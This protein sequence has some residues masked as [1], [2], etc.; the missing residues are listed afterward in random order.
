[1]HAT[2]V[3]LPPQQ[4]AA[5]LGGATYVNVHTSTLPGGALRGQLLPAAT[6][7]D[8]ASRTTGLGAISG[9]ERVPGGAAA[10]SLVGSN[11]AD[12]LR[13][14]GGA[15]TIVPARG[16]DVAGG[17]LGSDLIAWSNGDGSDTFDGEGDADRVQVNGAR[18]GMGEVFTVGAPG[19][20]VAFARTAPSPFTLDIGTTEKLAVAANDDADALTSTDL[21][22]AADLDELAFHGGNGDDTATI[23]PSPSVDGVARGGPGADTLRFDPGCL[24]VTTAPG[25]LT[26]A[27]LRPV[28]HASIETVDVASAVSFSAASGS[29]TEASGQAVIG[30][31]R[32]GTAAGTVGYTTT[33]LT[34]TAGSDYTTTA[35]TLTFGGGPGSARSPCR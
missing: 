35:G 25:S 23:A 21:S 4:E 5:L 10:D 8:V 2:G 14:G 28:T 33:P 11:A 34:A 3:A 9:V 29:F 1:M 32:S 22:G 13:G 27:G 18:G 30:L 15:D 26:A 24:A 16:V 6:A 20:R 17:G 12:T 7:V 31:T 19:T